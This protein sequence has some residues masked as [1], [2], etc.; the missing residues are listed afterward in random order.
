MG[1]HR[2]QSGRI[3]PGIMREQEIETEL[4][5]HEEKLLYENMR[6]TTPTHP[7]DA[8]QNGGE[9]PERGNTDRELTD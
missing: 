9:L 7:S 1:V 5:I 3:T 6:E 4:V 8:M 2:I